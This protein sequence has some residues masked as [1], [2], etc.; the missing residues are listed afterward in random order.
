LV[1]SLYAPVASG[2]FQESFR[3]SLLRTEGGHCLE[4]LVGFVARREMLTEVLGAKD[5]G[6]IGEL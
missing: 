1:F 6:H 2:K 4:S 5:L 3:E